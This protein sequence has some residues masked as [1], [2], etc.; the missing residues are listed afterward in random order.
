MILKVMIYIRYKIINNLYVGYH[1]KNPEDLED[2]FHQWRDYEHIVNIGEISF[3]SMLTR[4]VIKIRKVKKYIP[5]I[6]CKTSY[7]MATHEVIAEICD[8]GIDKDSS[9]PN[10]EINKISVYSDICH[11]DLSYK[12]GTPSYHRREDFEDR[13]DFMN[14]M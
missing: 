3:S 9:C 6:F 5:V 8:Y 2:K 7:D 1:I 11:D 14:S 10:I 12:K 13:I 4:Y